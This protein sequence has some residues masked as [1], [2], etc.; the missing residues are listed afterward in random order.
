MAKSIETYMLEAHNRLKTLLNFCLDNLNHNPAMAEESFIKFK[1][2]IEKHFFMEE[3]MIFSNTAIEDSEH[4]EE[5]ENI[6]EEHKQILV[7]IKSI[8]FDKSR[9]HSNKIENLKNLLEK[10]SQYEDEDFYPRLDEILTFEQK[11][12]MILESRKILQP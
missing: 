12:S 7:L 8:E 3:K 1:W 2:N 5:I 11:N 10:H 9:L 6:L 4:S